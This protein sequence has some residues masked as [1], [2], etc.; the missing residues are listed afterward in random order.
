MSVPTYREVFEVVEIRYHRLLSSR[1]HCLLVG[2][3]SVSPSFAKS[4][5]ISYCLHH[6]LQCTLPFRPPVKK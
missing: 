6:R 4:Y 5:T 3:S 2:E 1:V